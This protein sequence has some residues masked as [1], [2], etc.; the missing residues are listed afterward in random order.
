MNKH[1]QLVKNGSANAKKLEF[2]TA[3]PEDPRS[4]SDHCGLMDTYLKSHR[5]RNHSVNTIKKE[6]AFFHH[7][8]LPYGICKN[9]ASRRFEL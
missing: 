6:K 9:F 3:T 4:Y 7:K 5:V 2:K 1:L 8:G